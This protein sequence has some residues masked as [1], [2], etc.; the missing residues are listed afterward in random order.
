MPAF[1]TELVLQG[2]AV[3]ICRTRTH[4]WRLSFTINLPMLRAREAEREIRLSSDDSLAAA[5]FTRAGLHA[6][7]RSILVWAV[8]SGS[9]TIVSHPDII[10]FSWVPDQHSLLLLCGTRVVSAAIFVDS[11]RSIVQAQHSAGSVVHME[12]SARL[13]RTDGRP[14]AC[15]IVP[16]GSAAVVLQQSLPAGFRDASYR[17]TLFELPALADLA[18]ST[19]YLELEDDHAAFPASVHSCNSA[20]AVCFPGCCT[21]VHALHPLWE[22]GRQISPVMYTLPGFHGP[23]WS[24]GH[25]AGISGAG[26]AQV[27]D[28][29]TGVVQVH[30]QYFTGTTALTVSRVQW[31]GSHRDRLLLTSSSLSRRSQHSGTSCTFSDQV[32]V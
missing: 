18:G 27:V 21:R 13:L 19:F 11:P 22:D 2:L 3:W 25:L 28:G 1:H 12:H 16:L 31:A 20:A 9:Y 17:L 14:V 10:A 29:A 24:C 23:S 15:D 32:L 4:S 8:P 30:W 7:Q 26:A 6:H 5:L